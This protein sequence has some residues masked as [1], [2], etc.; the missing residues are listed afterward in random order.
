MRQPTATGGAILLLGTVLLAAGGAARAAA[1]AD[2]TGAWLIQGVDAAGQTRGGVLHLTE[3]DGSLGGTWNKRGKSV[4]LHDVRYEDGKL[5]FWWYVDIQTTVI[6]LY[7][8]AEVDGDEL[9]GELREPHRVEP[10]T[11]K[12]I[13]VASPAP[14]AAS[15]APEDA[16]ADRPAGGG[17]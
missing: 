14:A 2:V 7:L 11:G 3:Q 12:R 1:P 16:A 13:R 15:T 17:D 9:K 6:R 4:E 5:S 8:T 10:L